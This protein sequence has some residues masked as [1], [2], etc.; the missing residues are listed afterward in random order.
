MAK[1]IRPFTLQ[2]YIC[3]LDEISTNQGALY[4]DIDYIQEC[5]N[6][7]GNDIYDCMAKIGQLEN[8]RKRIENRMV[9]Y[10]ER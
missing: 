4:D 1:N 10:Y 7:R 2:W 5:F 6:D 9:K 3:L 8:L